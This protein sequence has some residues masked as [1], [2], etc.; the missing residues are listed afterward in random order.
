ML[1]TNEH[2]A[3]YRY[4]S[5]AQPAIEAKKLRK[6]DIFNLYT[7]Q[8]KLIFLMEG[9]LEVE[10]ADMIRGGKEVAKGFFWFASMG[11]NLKIRATSESLLLIVRI[12]G[13]LMLCDS[14][15]M[16]R[17]VN[18]SKDNAGE[19]G[20]GGD[21]LYAATIC[22]CLWDCLKSLYYALSDGLR[23]LSFFEIKTREIFFL[24]RVYYTK[25]ELCRIFRPVLTDDLAFCD[26]VKNS[27]MKYKTI[28]DL[29]ASMNYSVSGFYKRFSAAFGLSPRQWIHKQKEVAIYN[30]LVTS[31]L[32][33]KNIAGKWGFASIQSL[34][35]YCR[36]FYNESPGQMR[37]I[38]RSMAEKNGSNCHG[39]CI[40]EKMK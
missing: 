38:R 40:T 20:E 31:N 24:F 14:Y 12:N 10:T 22:P 13:T 29:A 16:E 35:N 2:L 7:T 1:Y 5:S 9:S 30:D 33:I 21:H 28:N 39:R 32:N 25:G 6:N 18:E 27:W 4:D 36:K 26:A 8:H 34:S 15:S 3:C 23:C 11:Q 19:T 37:N 17:L